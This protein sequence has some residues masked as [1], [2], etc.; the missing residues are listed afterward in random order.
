M[1]KNYD[2]KIDIVLKLSVSLETVKKR[3]LE[4]QSQEKRAD[5]NEQIAIKRYKTY[6]KSSEPVIDYYKRSNLLKVV[7]G[8]A[9][10]SE[11][12]I[13]ISGILETIKGWL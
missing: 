9:G 3:I 4:R 8:E 12:N 5:D 7:N 6:E 1:L 2:Q 10:I 13:E 11:I